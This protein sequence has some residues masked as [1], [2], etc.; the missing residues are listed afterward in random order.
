MDSRSKVSVPIWKVQ[1]VR[2][3]K[4]KTALRTITNSADAAAIVIPKLAGADRE[5]CLTVLLDTRNHVIGINTV[6]IGTVSASLVHPREVFKPA[7]LANAS[8][9]ILAHNHPSG[10]LEPSQQDVELTTR[11]LEAGRLVGIELVDHLIICE[12]AHF[13]LRASG[14]IPW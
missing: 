11:L 14:R 1:L 8:S 3:G 9:L 10:E 5:H 13:S 6:S 4:A 12:Q 7:M 2:D